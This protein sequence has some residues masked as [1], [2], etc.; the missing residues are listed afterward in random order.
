[1]LHLDDYFLLNARLHIRSFQKYS[2]A[3]REFDW[4]EQLGS[5]GCLRG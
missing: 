5:N 3:E 2:G 1:L 4:Q